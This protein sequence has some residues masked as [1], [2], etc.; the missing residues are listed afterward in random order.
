M[1]PVLKAWG[2]SGVWTVVGDALS[3]IARRE[4]VEDLASPRSRDERPI[5]LSTLDPANPYGASSLFSLSSVGNENFS[6]RRHEKSFLVLRAGLPILAIENRGERLTPLIVL[7]EKERR[8]AL[9][10]LP[11]ISRHERRVRAIRVCT[12]E[13]EP[14]TSSPAKKDLEAIGFVR[15]DLEMIYYRGYAEELRDRKIE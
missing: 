1:M 4:V 2:I 5:L 10:L 13:N 15:E 8:N 12:W 11:E 14:V 9:A 6:L 3:S 7:D